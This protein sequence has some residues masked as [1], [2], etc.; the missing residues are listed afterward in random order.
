[1]GEAY[2]VRWTTLDPDAQG[3][4]VSLWLV[5]AAADGFAD[6]RLSGAVADDDAL[7][8][9]DSLDMASESIKLSNGMPNV[10]S[11][12]GRVPQLDFDQ[13]TLWRVQV[14]S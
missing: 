9:D 4:V 5:P 10:G 14:C 8:V 2:S 6:E 1:M 13:P 3:K 12:D 7:T 11:Y